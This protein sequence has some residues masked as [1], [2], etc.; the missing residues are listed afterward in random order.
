MIVLA[1]LVVRSLFPVQSRLCGVQLDRQVRNDQFLV[2]GVVRPSFGLPAIQCHHRRLLDTEN[3]NR[4]ESLTDRILSRAFDIQF[5]TTCGEGQS[6]VRS[7]RVAF[8]VVNVGI[9]PRGPCRIQR[10][11]KRV[12]S[13]TRLV[14]SVGRFLV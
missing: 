11:E 1:S 2:R 6:T 14:D 4:L 5:A 7:R 12:R 13:L 3:G 10:Y 8:A 9:A